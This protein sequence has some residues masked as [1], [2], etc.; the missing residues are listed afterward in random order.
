MRRLHRLVPAATLA[1]GL[2]AG[3]ALAGCTSGGRTATP[4]PT[5]PSA[6]SPPGSTSATPS[7]TGSMPYPPPATAS[8]KAVSLYDFIEFWGDNAAGMEADFS[9]LE[10]AGATWA[11]LRL[12]SSPAAA[13]RFGSVVAAAQRHH[14]QLVVILEKPA[15]LLDLGSEADQ[16]AYRSW[17]AQIVRRYQ[18]SVHY[19]EILSE[20]NL[21]YTWNIDSKHDSDPQAY[22]AACALRHAAQAGLWTVKATDPTATVLFGGLSEAKVER[23]MRV[24]VTTDASRYFDIMDFHAYGQTP[25]DV[26]SRYRSFRRSMHSQPGLGRQAD[27]GG[28]R[29]QLLLERQG[30]LLRDRGA[31]GAQLRQGDQAGHRGRG[32]GP[33]FWFTLHG[34]NP[35]SPGYGL[36]TRDKP[37]PQS[38]AAQ[39]VL[40]PEG[41]AR[42]PGTGARR[43][44]PRTVARGGGAR[45]TRP[46]TGVG[47]RAGRSRRRAR[48]AG[49]GAGASWPGRTRR[50]RRARTVTEPGRELAAPRYRCHRPF[51]LRETG[52]PSG[53]PRCEATSYDAPVK[54]TGC[55]QPRARSRLRTPIRIRALGSSATTQPRPDREAAQLGARERVVQRPGQRRHR[56]QR[57]PPPATAAVTATATRAWPAPARSRDRDADDHGQERRREG[58]V[59]PEVAGAG[60]HAPAWWRRAGGPRPGP[61]A[62]S[63]PPPPRRRT[64]T[65]ARRQDGQLHAAGRH[66]RGAGPG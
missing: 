15:P 39:G 9:E 30:R 47:D 12:A 58:R 66:V 26:L 2:L 60:Q 22:L 45:A 24:V 34:N 53:G 28:V 43:R 48:P 63:T 50:S 36:I 11:R 33:I 51:L 40:R 20:P 21:R 44:P 7:P 56:G 54:S 41:H 35:D 25:A 18:A 17:V 61:A 32:A 64:T 52:W 6:T 37:G 16:Q 3:S 49:P 19:W 23:Y 57:E 10:A 55:G 14:I 27:L 46:M 62:G 8:G 31:E 59:V 42:P 29:L 4:S 1:V 13:D 65:R 5:Q 38:A